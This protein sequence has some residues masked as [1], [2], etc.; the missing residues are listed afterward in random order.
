MNN[1]NIPRKALWP[2]YMGAAA[3]QELADAID[4]VFGSTVDPMVEALRYLR[5][6]DIYDE[7]EN[8]L[9]GA[10]L[11]PVVQKIKSRDMIDA[12]L[13]DHV[14]VVTDRLR[15]NQLG[16]RVMDPTILDS[17]SVARLVGNIGPFWYLKGL[18]TFLD[19]IAYTLNIEIQYAN[20]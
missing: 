14:D 19:F 18:G 9:A 12:S 11:H 13:Y 5:R 6:V 3:W 10:T 17:G 20:L 15:L 2:P 1:R 8:T 16:L 4:E 7:R